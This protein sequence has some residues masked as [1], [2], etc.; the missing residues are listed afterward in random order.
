[1][2]AIFVLGEHTHHP[3]DELAMNLEIAMAMSSDEEIRIRCLE[4]ALQGKERGV[5]QRA[6]GYYLFTKGDKKPDEK[7]Q[8]LPQYTQAGEARRVAPM[9]RPT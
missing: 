1:M 6:R 8:P 5:I 9:I 7:P 4:L 3:A 2:A